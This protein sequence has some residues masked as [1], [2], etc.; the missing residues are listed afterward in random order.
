[1]SPFELLT[2]WPFPKMGH[3][4]IEKERDRT[5]FL[6]GKERLGGLSPCVAS[7]KKLN[8]FLAPYVRERMLQLKY[9]ILSSFYRHEI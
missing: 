5:G 8:K 2:D 3:L 4:F 7:G 6:P 1:M 9:N